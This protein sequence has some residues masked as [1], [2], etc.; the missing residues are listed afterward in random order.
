MWLGII[1]RLNEICISLMCL[2]LQRMAVISLLQ[3]DALLCLP[4]PYTLNPLPHA[5]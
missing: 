4:L 5:F 1:R 2:V 3:S